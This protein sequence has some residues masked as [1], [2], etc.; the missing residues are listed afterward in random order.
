MA[1][2]TASIC[3]GKMI[4][5]FHCTRNE[6]TFSD[7]KGWKWFPGISITRIGDP[8]RASQPEKIDFASVRLVSQAGT[9]AK[10]GGLNSSIERRKTTGITRP[11]SDTEGLYS[12]R[13]LELIENCDLQSSRNLTSMDLVLLRT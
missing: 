6:R 2:E 5:N 4:R 9:L 11:S 7:S 10:F 8:E 12:L 3:C 13:S 1:S